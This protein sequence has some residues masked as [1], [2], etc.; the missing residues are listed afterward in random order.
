MGFH[1]YPGSSRDGMGYISRDSAMHPVCFTALFPSLGNRNFGPEV[2]SVHKLYDW[3]YGV[4][5]WDGFSK[6]FPF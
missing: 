6:V 4:Y 5:E 1:P 3:Y 2:T